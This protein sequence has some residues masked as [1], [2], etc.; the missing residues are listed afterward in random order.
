MHNYS[1]FC[2]LTFSTFKW[3]CANVWTVKWKLLISLKSQFGAH[4]WKDVLLKQTHEGMFSYSKQ[5]KGYIMFRRNIN[6]IPQ[7]VGGRGFDLFHLISLCWWHTCIGLAYIAL[8]SSV[9]G[10]FI[11]RNLPKNFL[12]GSCV[13]SCHFCGLDW[14]GSLTVSFV[15]NCPCWF[16]CCVYWVDYIVADGLCVVFARWTGLQL[17]IHAWCLLLD[18]TAGSLT[19]KKIE[20]APK[21]YL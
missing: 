21:K 10:D 5:V 6:M 9:Y 2:L 11:D 13:A 14:L 17:L 3:F 15:L 16:M 1:H 7:T 20:I 4:R 8:L 18:W 19:R 12:W